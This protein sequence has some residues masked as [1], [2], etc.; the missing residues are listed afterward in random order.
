[1]ETPLKISFQGGD[2]SEALSALIGENVEALEKLHGRLTA[3]QV[4]VQ[5]PDHHRP[6]PASSASRSTSPCRAAST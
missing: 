2:A 6:G 4:S 1:M 3:C 5:G